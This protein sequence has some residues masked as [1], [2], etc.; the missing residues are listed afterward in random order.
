[1]KSHYDQIR[2]SVYYYDEQNRKW[3]SNSDSDSD[4]LAYSQLIA[5]EYE[6]AYIWDNIDEYIV[7]KNPR[8]GW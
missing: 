4:V 2:Y 7:Y 1:M 6:Y 5:N 3:L 8:I